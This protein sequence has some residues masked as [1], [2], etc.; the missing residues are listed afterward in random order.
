[1]E[2]P[3]PPGRLAQTQQQQQHQ[4]VQAT[5]AGGQQ[6]ADAEDALRFDAS[7][8]TPPARLE[9]RLRQSVGREAG[10]GG[11]WWERLRRRLGGT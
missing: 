11:S 3:R 2:P 5:Q 9:E 1:M 4:Q 10:A 8:T 7:Q 6:F